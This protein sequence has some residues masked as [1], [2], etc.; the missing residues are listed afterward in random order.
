VTDLPDYGT[1]IELSDR[2]QYEIAIAI[3]KEAFDAGGANDAWALEVDQLQAKLA[4]LNSTTVCDECGQHL[5]A[6][7]ERD[8]LQAKLAAAE[9]HES[10]LA[11]LC[12]WINTHCRE[13]G[14][15]EADWYTLPLMRGAIDRIVFSQRNREH[16]LRTQLA[17]AEAERDLERKD[18]TFAEFEM[19]AL[20]DRLSES[21]AKIKR[22]NQVLNNSLAGIEDAYSGGSEQ[23]QKA[24]GE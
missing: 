7:H 16:D 8:E 6:C 22:L 11:S 21:E 13:C 4:K 10:T 23:A 2:D 14:V 9:A 19:L 15:E 5:N 17:A 18:R 1:W 3:Q 24:G 20:R 12:D